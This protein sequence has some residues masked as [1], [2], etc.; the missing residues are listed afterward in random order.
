MDCIVWEAHITD[1]IRDDGRWRQVWA[2]FL[3]LC[4]I[5]DDTAAYPGH[6]SQKETK[7][8]KLHHVELA[9]CYK[10]PRP[11]KD[12]LEEWKKHL[13]WPH[14]KGHAS[15]SLWLP[16]G[17]SKDFSDANRDGSRWQLCN[18]CYIRT[19]SSH[20]T[21]S[22]P[23]P[24]PQHFV[25]PVEDEEELVRE[26]LVTL[27]NRL[28]ETHRRKARAG[29]AMLESRRGV[30]GAGS[31]SLYNHAHVRPRGAL[32]HPP[33]GYNTWRKHP[34]DS[35]DSFRL[36]FLHC[37][38]PGR[39]MSRHWHP[40]FRLAQV[41]TCQEG[42]LRLVRA[43]AGATPTPVWQCTTA[44]DGHLWTL[45]YQLSARAAGR[46]RLTDCFRPVLSLRPQ[47]ALSVRTPQGGE[48]GR[49]TT[50]V[51]VSWLFGH[52]RHP[53]PG[54][55]HVPTSPQEGNLDRL[56]PLTAA[57]YDK[58]SGRNSKSLSFTRQSRGSE[59]G[60]AVN[61]EET[62][63]GEWD[64]APGPGKGEEEDE[65]ASEIGLSTTTSLAWVRSGELTPEEDGEDDVGVGKGSAFCEVGLNEGGV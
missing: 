44:E 54:T 18:G 63:T 30:S 29:K 50:P 5:P 55:E 56:S 49:S 6:S 52:R 16:R 57:S 59:G 37:V 24:R 26:L 38:P 22:S 45:S 3:K 53:M 4:T 12:G 65:V 42:T 15:L 13:L 31:H 8:G 43:A 35:I 11:F 7:Q 40:S 33:N 14:R 1:L 46:L 25:S 17:R 20:V 62:K 28:E 34:E 41:L 36:V 60:W 64:L 32:Y 58:E 47:P 9:R 27:L 48:G 21:T 19:P 61:G 10:D 51:A 2:T 23:S 39:S